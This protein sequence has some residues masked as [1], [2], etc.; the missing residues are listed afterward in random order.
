MDADMEWCAPILFLGLPSENEQMVRSYAIA[1]SKVVRY[2]A[3][4]QMCSPL[5]N[6]NID[7]L[8][9]F[10]TISSWSGHKCLRNESRTI[11]AWYQYWHSISSSIQSLLSGSLS[12]QSGRPWLG[13]TTGTQMF[14][15]LELPYHVTIYR[16]LAADAYQLMTFTRV[17]I[18]TN[19]KWN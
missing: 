1:N 13:I 9:F 16:L 7:D 17:K 6:I 14:D 12:S 4:G 15:C 3:R 19:T 10:T 11:I 5:D 8:R 2:F 18:F